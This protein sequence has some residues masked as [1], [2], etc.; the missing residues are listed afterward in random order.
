MKRW[1]IRLLAAAALAAAAVAAGCGSSETATTTTSAKAWASGLCGA[2]STY[3][4]ALKHTAGTFKGNPTSAGLD[5]ARAEAKSATDSFK[6]T[7]KGL[8]RPETGSGKQAKQALDALGSQLSKDA[9]TMKA[10]TDSVNGTEGLLNAVSVV[11]GTLATAKTQITTTVDELRS[12][13][14]GELKDA[15]AGADSCTALAQD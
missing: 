2:L 1:R 14:H 12:L 11:T 6:A 7:V 10:A 9:E 13:E 5:Q 8:G 4:Q 3:V 15:F